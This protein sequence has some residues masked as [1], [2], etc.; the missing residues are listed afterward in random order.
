MHTKLF[1]LRRYLLSA[2]AGIAVAYVL[3]FLPLPYY[4]LMP[5]TAEALK[6]MVHIEQGGVPEKGV[7]MLTTV[8]GGEAN[9]LYYLI[10][11]VHP[12]EEIVKKEEMF[13]KGVSEQD[14]SQ[15]QQY[16]M[17]TSQSDAMTAAYKKANIPYHIKNEG[18]MVL[19][20]LPGLPAAK[21]LRGGDY[22]LKVDET[23][24]T[25]AQ[26][27]LDY[28]KNKHAGETIS[29]SYR[30]DNATYKAPITL[31]TL[32][33]E[34]DE[35]GNP[36]PLRPGLGISPG[37]VQ[38]V[39]AEDAAKQLS[40]K[41]EDIG[42]PS[43]GLMFSLEMYTQLTGTDLTKGYRIAGTGTITPDGDVG[44]IGGIEH[45][46]IAADREGAD[47]FFAPKDI[48]PKAGEKFEPI[49]NYTDAVNRANKINAKMKVVPIGTMDEA[50]KYLRELTPKSS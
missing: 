33:Q 17:L 38:S 23:P 6:P 7:F 40:V 11:K 39:Q 19:R 18:V 45:K 46:I 30:R 35:R 25:K 29:I 27:L 26:D 44:P 41:T 37:D 22:L 34:K 16:V 31:G 42:G 32:P 48:Y 21:V 47:I 9:V 1:Q 5:G 8:R 4:I 50:L 10:A 2:L 13:G 12:Y 14:Y 28:V 36:L 15:R 49:L 3:F 20:T 43:A 24:I